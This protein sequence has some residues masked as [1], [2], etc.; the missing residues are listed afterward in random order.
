MARTPRSEH[1]HESYRSRIIQ[2]V[3]RNWRG[4]KGDNRRFVHRPALWG[5][6]AVN[7]GRRA[8]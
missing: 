8:F 5:N 3:P 7:R 6:A 2:A 1:Q 4:G